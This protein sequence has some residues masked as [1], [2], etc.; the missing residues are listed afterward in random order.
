MCH[1]NTMKTAII[2]TTLFFFGLIVQAQT[3][4]T[5]GP[6]R[7]YFAINPGQ[8]Q[9]EKIMISNPS[10]DYT[11]E[12]GV[13]FE[14]WEYSP[15]GENLNYAPGTL[16]T[17]C[18][19]W[20]TLPEAF[21]SLKPGES[22]EM[23]I[24]MTVPANYQNDTVPVHTAMLFV[25]QLNPRDGVDKNGAN[26]QIAVRTGIKLYR[27]PANRQVPDIEIVNFTKHQD[28]IR[29]WVTLHFNNVGKIWAD[30]SISMELLD[31]ST[32]EKYELPISDF[33]SMP[34]D[35]RKH[36][37]LLPADLGK[38]SYIAT[39]IVNYGDVSTVKIA[40]LEFSI[41]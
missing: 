38:G 37:L 32:G 1:L 21:F 8:S 6:P 22:K 7:V 11:L 36:Q 10:P 39:A 40:E 5:I 23:D 27:R 14:D 17:S 2:S 25:T 15:T 13:S 29:H 20:V 26:I 19:S 28:S 18:V 12:L 9:T 41:E 35:Q 33:Y 31:Q 16:P 24:Q 4:I 30:G 34:G 3:G